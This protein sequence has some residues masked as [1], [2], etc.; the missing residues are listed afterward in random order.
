MQEK[1]ISCVSGIKQKTKHS[2]SITSLWKKAKNKKILDVI[3]D[4][5]LNFKSHMSELC[6][7][8]SQKMQLYLDCLVIY[9]TLRKN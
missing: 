6:K 7:K 4:N 5:R 1:V 8:S 3:I 2:Y 9:T